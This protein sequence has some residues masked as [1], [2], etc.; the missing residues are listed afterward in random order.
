MTNLLIRISPLGIKI[1]VLAP[2]GYLHSIGYNR[3][4]HTYAVNSLRAG[5]DA[6]TVQENLGHVSAAFTLDVYVHYTDDMRRDSANRMEAF[7]SSIISE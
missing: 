4:R 1:C 6:K 5:D 2:G 7:I 3:L